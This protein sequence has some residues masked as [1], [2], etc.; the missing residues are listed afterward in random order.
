MMRLMWTVVATIVYLMTA[1]TLP[2]LA[3]FL[4]PFYCFA[5]VLPYG[6]SFCERRFQ[7][8]RHHDG[9]DGSAV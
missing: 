7:R 2:K 1:A 6:V 5:V 4:V 9:H 3:A 8:Y